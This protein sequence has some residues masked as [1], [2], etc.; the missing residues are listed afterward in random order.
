MSVREQVT[1][2][3]NKVRRRSH[4]PTADK[5]AKADTVPSS[6][7]NSPRKPTLQDLQNVHKQS[8]HVTEKAPSGMAPLKA[9]INGNDTLLY[10][11]SLQA[12]M[13]SH[14]V[15]LFCDGLSVCAHVTRVCYQ[16]LIVSARGETNPSFTFSILQTYFGRLVDKYKH[17][18]QRIN[19][20]EGGTD[21]T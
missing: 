1:N 4:D 2:F 21:N 18:D 13:E 19:S 5:Y 11:T 6:T 14:M 12:Q 10:L 17:L 15:P 9:K 7:N 20:I 3:S 8:H 16:Q